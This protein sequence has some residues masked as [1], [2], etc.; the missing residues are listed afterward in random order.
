MNYSTPYRVIPN[1]VGENRS[2]L[3]DEY[4]DT[5]SKDRLCQLFE[6]LD[7]WE[8]ETTEDVMSKTTLNEI[9]KN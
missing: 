5:E 9:D 8:K 2:I 7:E 1:K 3:L 4:Q 6:L